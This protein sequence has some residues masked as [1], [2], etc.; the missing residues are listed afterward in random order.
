[1]YNIPVTENDIATYAVDGVLGL[2]EAGPSAQARFFYKDPAANTNNNV[3]QIGS[4]ANDL[5]VIGGMMK[6]NAWGARANT[7]LEVNGAQRATIIG[8]GTAEGG[9]VTEASNIYVHGENTIVSVYG[10]GGAGFTVGE[11]NINIAEGKIYRLYGGGYGDGNW[12]DAKQITG[13]QYGGDVTGDVNIVAT[14]GSFWDLVFGGGTG[15]VGGNV[16]LDF[17]GVTSTANIYGGTYSSQADVAIA[18]NVDM[19]F[20]NGDR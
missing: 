2:Q 12:A 5:F 9:Q 18:G 3:A 17:S 6:P 20:A 13:K 14:G 7:W 1:M 16:S 10:G 15:N 19:K 4:V 8:G 11:V